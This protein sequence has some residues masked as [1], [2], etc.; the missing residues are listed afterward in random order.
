[1]KKF[2]GLYDATLDGKGR[3]VLPAPVRK[4]L[5]EDFD[6]TFMILEGLDGNLRLYMRSTWEPEADRIDN[7]PDGDN[8]LRQYKFMF[9]SANE[10]ELDTQDRI[11]I[12]KLLQD[13]ASIKKEIVI[14]GWGDHFLLWDKEAY[15]NY[16]TKSS[17][18]YSDNATFVLHNY[19]YKDK[20]VNHA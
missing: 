10:I 12:P 3:M 4:M 18:N 9:L 8:K 15:N 2:R 20:E 13:C 14:Q 1:M 16:R 7:L 5:P 11:S 17:E 6:K 19:P